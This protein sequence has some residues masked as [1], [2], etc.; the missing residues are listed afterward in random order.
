MQQIFSHGQS[1]DES[2]V[3]VFFFLKIFYIR[4]YT[5]IMACTTMMDS[6]EF[7]IRYFL[8]LL[9]K[10]VIHIIISRYIMIA[11]LNMSHVGYSFS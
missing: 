2:E 11:F 9:S 8:N 7:S 5:L 10:N 1:C 4:L 3:L 6:K